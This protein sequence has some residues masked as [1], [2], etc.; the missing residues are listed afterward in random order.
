MGHRNSGGFT[1]VELLVVVAIL[2]IISAIA[3]PNLLNAID[4]GKQKRTMADM[5][6]IGEAIET[7]SVDTTI[8][9]N[10]NDLPS[11]EAILRP[12]YIRVWPGTDGWQ[13]TLVYVPDT[14]LGRGYTLRSTGKDGISEANPAGGSTGDFD[15][16]IVFVNGQFMQWPEGTQQ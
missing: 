9:P 15:C 11:L 6:A 2:G 16:D 3:V 14:A 4:Q 7:Y 8:Y 12:T 10:V 5:R 1:L 13:N